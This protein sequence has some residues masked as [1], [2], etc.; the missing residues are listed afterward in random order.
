[1][2][3]YTYL[4]GTKTGLNEPL[5]VIRCY[6]QE[7]YEEACRL[8]NRYDPTSK[9]KDFNRGPFLVGRLHGEQTFHCWQ[10]EGHEKENADRAE[11]FIDYDEYFNPHMVS[12]LYKSL[13]MDIKPKEQHE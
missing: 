11:Q 6:D 8:F 10:N 12:D 1:M 13:G 7:Q 2:D 3:T 5:C 4:H 9:V